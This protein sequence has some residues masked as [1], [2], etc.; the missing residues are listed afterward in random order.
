VEIDFV[1]PGEGSVSKNIHRWI[2][3]VHVR[4]Y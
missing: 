1:T 2:I 4:G 3:L